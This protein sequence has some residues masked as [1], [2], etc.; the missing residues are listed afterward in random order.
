M[1]H[2][3]NSPTNS[4]PYII[5]PPFLLVS[6]ASLSLSLTFRLVAMVGFSRI[7]RPTPDHSNSDLRAASPYQELPPSQYRAQTTLLAPY[8]DD[9]EGN[10]QSPYARDYD[11]TRRS[12]Y[13]RDSAAPAVINKHDSRARPPPKPNPDQRARSYISIYSDDPDTDAA[14]LQMLRRENPKLKLEIE[15]LKGHVDALTYV[16]T[17]HISYT[18]LS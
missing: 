15:R 8:E 5:F 11:D 2:N 6:F 1:Q 12:L 7:A 13:A 17:E 14:E 10:R 18:R 9:Y 16:L 3:P 4:G